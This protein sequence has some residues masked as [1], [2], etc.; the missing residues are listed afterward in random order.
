LYT[1]GIAVVGKRTDCGAAV[2]DA[3]VS[4]HSNLTGKFASAR[5]PEYYTS[6]SV[7]GKL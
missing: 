6:C 4:G 5:P 7:V 2:T 3:A 1:G